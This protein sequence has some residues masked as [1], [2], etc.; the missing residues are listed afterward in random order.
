MPSNIDKV[1]DFQITIYWL[2]PYSNTLPFPF[3]H[4]IHKKKYAPHF[5][6][7]FM[8]RHWTLK[9]YMKFKQLSVCSVLKFPKN[10]I[11]SV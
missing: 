2:Y 3:N 11:I 5:K 1:S 10:G 9:F 6:T 8:I 4:F 7:N